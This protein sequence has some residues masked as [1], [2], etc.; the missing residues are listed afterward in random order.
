MDADYTVELGADDPVLD[1]PWS[2]PE[3]R[4]EYY[5]LKKQPELLACLP[6][7]QQFPRL[8]D[9]LGAVNSTASLFESAK[10][11]L[12]STRELNPEEEVFGLPWKFASYVDLVFTRPDRRGLCS[13][14]ELFARQLV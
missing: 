6:E 8:G 12:W 1:L 11:D 5:D 9:F 2:D 3:R 7:V 4:I 13:V 14:H 10:S